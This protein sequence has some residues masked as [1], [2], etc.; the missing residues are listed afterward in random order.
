M[1]E[2]G[3]IQFGDSS[4]IL[5]SI[6]DRWNR[7]T[8]TAPDYTLYSTF[9]LKTYFLVFWLI[10]FCHVLTIYGVKRK[11]SK[12]FLKTNPLNKLCHCLEIMNIP[13]PFED[14]DSGRG[15]ALEH[16]NRLKACRKENLLIILTNSVYNLL[17][18]VPIFCLGKYGLVNINKRPYFTT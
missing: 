8:D 14:W 18:I 3:K 6:V 16:F 2:E 12:G 5:W 11:T 15:N 10:F 1:N 13:F 17:L 9:T 4:P 7:T